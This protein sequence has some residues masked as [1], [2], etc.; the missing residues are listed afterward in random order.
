M[1]P[2][3]A[4]QGATIIEWV[5]SGYDNAGHTVTNKVAPA[6]PQ[7]GSF[8]L[9]V[10]LVGPNVWGR[11]WQFMAVPR[12][13]S[14]GGQIKEG[15]RSPVSDAVQPHGAPGKPDV[16]VVT[17]QGVTGNNV[18][19]LFSITPGDG[20]GNPSSSMTLTYSSPW[21]NGTATANQFVLT[22][23]MTAAGSVTV[24]QT[25]GDLSYSTG[26]IVLKPTIG[27][28]AATSVLTVTYVPE[29]PLFCEVLATDGTSLDNGKATAAPDGSPS[30]NTYTYSYSGIA[31]GTDITLQCG[32]SAGN[33]ATYKISTTR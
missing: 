27:V 22:L 21:G 28:D 4:S 6:N 3:D 5:V 18:T 31:V 25:A 11:T 13:Q 14:A 9:R 29:N 30:Y 24:R 23:P 19:L 15:G 17:Q 16:Q 12:V 2:T 1:G 8:S 26:T 7:D 20:N 32:P 33:T 10:T